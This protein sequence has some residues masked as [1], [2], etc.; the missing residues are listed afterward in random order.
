L[1][2]GRVIAFG[3]VDKPDEQSRAFALGAD[4]YLI[5]PADAPALTSFIR[6]IQE[7]FVTQRLAPRAGV[8]NLREA[9]LATAS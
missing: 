1:R 5:K 6:G 2:P 4:Q 8:A 3:S 7:S 9:T